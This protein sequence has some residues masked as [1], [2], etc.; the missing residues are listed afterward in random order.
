MFMFMF[1]TLENLT[2]QKPIKRCTMCEMTMESGDR[3]LKNE[4]FFFCTDDRRLSG[5][6]VYWVVLI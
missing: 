1:Y 3:F 5:P 4:R 6:T 2:A